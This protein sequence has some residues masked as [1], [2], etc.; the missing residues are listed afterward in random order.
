MA[1]FLPVVSSLNSSR[2]A[3]LDLKITNWELFAAHL[4]GVTQSL[5][6]SIE[7][8]FPSEQRL[9]RLL[10]CWLKICPHASWLHVLIALL[11]AKENDSYC[12]LLGKL[13]SK[14]SWVAS[15]SQEDVVA[16]IN[17]LRKRFEVILKEMKDALTISDIPLEKI[18]SEVE[19]FLEMEKGGLSHH[20]FNIDELFNELQPYCNYLN[21]ELVQFL[22]RFLK[23]TAATTQSTVSSVMEYAKNLLLLLQSAKLTFVVSAMRT[24]ASSKTKTTTPIKFK[25]SSAW[26]NYSVHILLKTL[27]YSLHVKRIYFCHIHWDKNHSILCLKVFLPKS[28]EQQLQALLKTNITND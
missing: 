20:V 6:Q 22:L 11:E 7:N 28:C 19:Q 14:R 15:R 23:G 18:V 3:L 25:L 4:P 16:D 26:W 2:P 13:T 24:P 12:N 10:Q 17:A 8:E 21:F 5:I 1:V 27:E 9:E